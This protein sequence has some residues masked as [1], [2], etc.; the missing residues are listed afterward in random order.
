MYQSDQDKHQKLPTYGV[1]RPYLVV[2]IVR[3]VT[4][5]SA[6]WAVKGGFGCLI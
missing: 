2:Y 1:R 4:G 6:Q 3:W 5:C